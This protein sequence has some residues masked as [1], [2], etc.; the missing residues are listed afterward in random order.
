MKYKISSLIGLIL[1]VFII[2]IGLVYTFAY[3]ENF[4][5]ECPTT[6][7]K[8]GNK[9]L[10]YNPTLAKIPGVNPIQMNELDDYEEYIH[11]QRTNNVRCPILYLDKNANT[12]QSK[13]Y[14]INSSDSMNSNDTNYGTLNHNLPSMNYTV[15][16]INENLGQ[17]PYLA[18]NLNLG[19]K[20]N[21]NYEYQ[22]QDQGQ[23][24]S[25]YVYERQFSRSDL[26]PNQ[27]N[28]ITQTTEQA[29]TC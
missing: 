1:I 18:Q 25:N 7:I 27:L 23:N 6:L 28:E 8:D 11:W 10:L 16:S 21:S 3:K 5:N 22:T 19:Q 17:H 2:C 29:D 24:H 4:G 13:M 15:P 9:I 26:Q 12:S 20:L 14:E